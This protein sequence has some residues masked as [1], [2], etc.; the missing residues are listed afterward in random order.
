[1]YD[2]RKVNLTSTMTSSYDQ[3][4]RQTYRPVHHV[5]YKYVVHAFRRLSIRRVLYHL[6]EGAMVLCETNLRRNH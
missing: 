4:D 5:C 2:E 6:S 1:M 3:H